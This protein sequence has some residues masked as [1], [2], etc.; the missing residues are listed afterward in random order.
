M[1]GTG[2]AGLEV[3][4]VSASY[5]RRHVLSD[6]TLAPV[7]AGQVVALVGPNAA[8]KSTLLRAL[9]GLTP[10]R[11]TIRLDGVD[12][13]DLSL[14]ERARRLT[15]MPQSL[16]AGVHL[17]VLESVIGA[18]RASGGLR[19]VPDSRSAAEQALATLQRCGIAD[20]ALRGLDALS[21]GQRQLAAL[22]QAVARR[23][24]LLLLD[25]PTSAL[26]LRHALE[27]MQLVRALAREE[28]TAVLMVL[29]DLQAAA[30]TADRLVVLSNGAVAADGSPAEAIT[31]QMLASVYGVR[32]R[33][34]RE[35]DA[36]LH[37]AVDDVI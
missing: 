32:G 11:G 26:D 22:A 30:R 25:E 36:G 20:L 5:G 16:P 24:R 23:P 27:V 13:Q 15:Y 1:S 17:N 35:G 34:W 21:G 3:L 31:P 18:L 9:A 14:A 6:V 4:A 37:V 33:V 28:G 19:D 7:R 12:L 29:H 2:E 10:S 8:G